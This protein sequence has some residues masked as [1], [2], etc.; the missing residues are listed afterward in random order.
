M[1]TPLTVPTIRS[2]SPLRG[3]IDS[4]RS[5]ATSRT[6]PLTLSGRREVFGEA[7][8]RAAPSALM[9]VASSDR[10]EDRVM[11]RKPGL[12]AKIL[13]QQ[14]QCR[15]RTSWIPLR[16]GPAPDHHQPL[17]R[18]DFAIDSLRPMIVL[19]RPAHVDA[20]RAAR[21][22]IVFKNRA[23]ETFWTPPSRH[24]LG[25]GPCFEHKAARR[26]EDALDLQHAIGGVRSEVNRSSLVF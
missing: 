7:V 17:R 2:R 8:Q 13:E 10:F 1:K 21:T 26:I 11:Q 22:Q 6:K 5:I 3:V 20:I 18:N 14:C 25:F 24:V 15:L 16:I 12:A 4:A 9:R 19:V 23:G